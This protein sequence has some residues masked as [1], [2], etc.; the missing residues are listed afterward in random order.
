VN[1]VYRFDGF[2][3]AGVSETVDT[4]TPKFARV[5]PTTGK[6]FTIFKCSATESQLWYISEISDKPGTI[7][8]IDYY[9]AKDTGSGLP[10]GRWIT[11]GSGVKPA[12]KHITI[13]RTTPLPHDE[14]LEF[15]V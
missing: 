3:D 9:Q 6:R 8:D 15:F 14:L 12:P 1:G 13:N 4:V 7:S 2:F 11:C 5:D 10:E